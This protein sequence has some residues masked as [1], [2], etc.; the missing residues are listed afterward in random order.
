ML[1]QAHARALSQ[2]QMPSPSPAAPQPSA[3]TQAAVDNRS[4][5]LNAHHPTYHQ[6]RGAT[7]AEARAA[8]TV[9]AARS[10]PQTRATAAAPPKK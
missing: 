9:A 1:S 5:Q 2:L 6:S 3:A 8:A 4:V 7:P 10:N